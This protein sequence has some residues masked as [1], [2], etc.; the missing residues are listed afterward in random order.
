MRLTDDI[1]ERFKR[2]WAAH[3]DTWGPLKDLLD[4]VEDNGDD[5]AIGD[6]A[7]FF[8][9]GSPATSAANCPIPK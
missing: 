7:A 2:F 6:P 5:K 8:S 4:C 3:R 1:K 9:D